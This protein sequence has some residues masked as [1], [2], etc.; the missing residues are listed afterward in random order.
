MSITGMKLRTAAPGGDWRSHETL[1]GLVPV[2]EGA[3]DKL[4]DTVGVY[5][6]G[7]VAGEYVAFLYHA[8]KIVLPKDAGTGLSIT[9]WAKVYYNAATKK[10]TGVAAQNL[11]VAIC[12]KA[13]TATDTEVLVDFKGDKAHS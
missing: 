1:V 5:M 3:M 11:W 6:Q 12:L 4:E 10:L 13:A 9:Q 7:A 8:E 2:V